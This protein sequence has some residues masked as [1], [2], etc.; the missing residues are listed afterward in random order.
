MRGEDVRN[1]S[2]HV[3]ARHCVDHLRGDVAETATAR[4][5]DEAALRHMLRGQRPGHGYSSR[6]VQV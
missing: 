4:V 6:L 5:H 1:A 3:T 2:L